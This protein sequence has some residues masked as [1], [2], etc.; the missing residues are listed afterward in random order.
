MLSKS[1]SRVFFLAFLLVAG[2]LMPAY[3]EINFDF[4]LPLFGQEEIRFEKTKPTDFNLQLLKKYLTEQQGNM[5]T[6]LHAITRWF[7][8][9]KLSD[10]PRRDELIRIGRDYFASTGKKE[11]GSEERLRDIFFTGLLL[12]TEKATEK[13]NSA[14]HEFEELLLD[15]ED[16]LAKNADYWLIKGIVFHVLRNRPNGYFEPMKPEEDLKKALTLIPRTA[17]YYYVMGQAFRF[18]GS[19]DSSLF[20]SIASYEK[21]SSLDARNPKLQNSLLSIYMGLHEDYQS[22]NKPEPF[23]LEEAVYKKILEV[24][25]NNPHALNNLG[26]LYAEYGVNTQVAQDLCQ[27]AVDMAPENPGFHDSLGWAAF[28]N[29]DFKKAEEEL[30]KSLA[31]RMNVYDPHYHLATVY[32]A[33][34]ELEKAAE[35]YEQAIKIRPDSAEA[36][37]NLAYLLT[38]QN[39]DIPKA[40]TMAEAAVKLEPTNAS[41]LDTLGWAY[42]RN[43]ESEKALG[44]LLKAAQLVPG[45]GEVLL[46]IGRVYLDKS[47][48]EAALSYLKEA[49]KADPKLNDPDNSLYLAVR[50]KSYHTA[51][52]DYH[53]LLGERADKEKVNSILM[54]IARLYQEEKLYDK[55]I[56]I[57][58]LCSEIKAGTRDLKEALL[59]GYE[60]PA[61]SEKSDA[62]VSEPAPA[63]EL[64]ESAP[65]TA[66][67]TPVADPEPVDKL[68]SGLPPESEHSLIINFGPQFFKWAGSF[69]KG[70]ASLADKSITIFMTRIHK[71]ARSAIIRVDTEATPGTS[72]LALLDNYFAQL[73]IRSANSESPDTRE[74]IVG[75]HRLYAV[76]DRNAVY[77]SRKALNASGALELP[78][79]LCTFNPD[80][81][82]EIIYNWEKLSSHIHKLLLPL[83]KN[84]FHPFVRIYTRYTLKDGS[85]NEFSAATTGKPE[86]EEFM[87]KFARELFTFKLQ[88]QNL[89]I[90]TTIKVRSDK[91]IIYISTDFENIAGWLENRLKLVGPLVQKVLQHYLARTS[92]FLNRMLYAPE[93]DKACPAGGKI[94]SDAASGLIICSQ[95]RESPAIPMILDE[96]ICCRHNRDRLFQILGEKGTALAREA[97][98]ENYLINKAKELGIQMCPTAGAWTIDEKGI[99]C[100]DHEN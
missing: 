93:L 67:E 60:L 43:G 81:F 96:E 78:G 45:Q 85:L 55:A 86:G 50:L 100:S 57:T 4:G 65:V 51:L 66:S 21:A 91:E 56:D 39:R 89:G 42:Y 22:R 73:N 98:D 25:P 71:S 63:I 84:P 95:H 30:K 94:K 34:G 6:Q 49:F 27:K 48:F 53:S 75:K 2:L 52:A 41:Y 12:S 58:R 1:F 32:Y 47:D 92:C 29:R 82:V 19:M 97:K 46:H 3:S 8:L 28:K 77:I 7:S 26:Y 61:S 69:V 10:T 83:I 18:L 20:L 16:R 38:E 99:N 62:A 68:F 54:S 70:A 5:I 79:Q 64:P 36:L 72:L 76:A 88:A 31:M 35:N 74:F 14:D 24:S 15:S 87:K 17:Q 59:P 33:T 37:N 90:T 44:H 11:F 23:W 13:E 40:L 80:G 9:I